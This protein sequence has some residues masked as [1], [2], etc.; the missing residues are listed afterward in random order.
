MNQPLLALCFLSTVFALTPQT[1]AWAMQEHA[2][3]MHELTR[4]FNSKQQL[5][6]QAEG[7]YRVCLFLEE[8]TLIKQK[9]SK[10]SHNLSQE[11]LEIQEINQKLQSL[12]KNENSLKFRIKEAEN[13]QAGDFNQFL[14][15]DFLPVTKVFSEKHPTWFLTGD[16]YENRNS[17]T[18]VSSTKWLQPHKESFLIGRK[19]TFETEQFKQEKIEEFTK[20]LQE[21]TQAQ[22]EIIAQLQEA[23]Q[24]LSILQQEQKSSNEFILLPQIKELKETFRSLFN[25]ANSY[26]PDLEQLQTEQKNL[27]NLL[28]K[29]DPNLLKQIAED[30]EHQ[31]YFSIL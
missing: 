14:G 9:Q 28:L 26:A 16:V 5:A 13:Y 19:A 23:Q 27:Q 11:K 20:E 18:Y 24:K 25:L 1:S 15:I 22:Q 4:P 2:T 8:E 6:K 7:F 21:V 17:Y 29:T 10:S 3:P 12:K 31:N 30:K